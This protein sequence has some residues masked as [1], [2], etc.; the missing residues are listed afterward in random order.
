MAKIKTSIFY[1]PDHIKPDD[2]LKRTTHLAIG[3]HPDDIEM[4]AYNGIMECFNQQDAWFGGIV[5][6]NGSGSSRTGPYKTYT[7]KQMVDARMQEQIHAATIG[8]YSF[9][10]MYGSNSSDIFK[11]KHE[12]VIELLM[13]VFVKI[14]PKI[15]YTHNLLDK[16]IT[17]VQTALI[18]IEALRRVEKDYI[19]EKLYG[20]E[21]WR[22]LDWIND[23]AKVILDV[24]K[25]P[26]LSSQLLHVFNSQ[27]VGGKAYDEGTLGRRRAHAVFENARKVDR[28]HSVTLAIDLKPLI[29]NHH[30]NIEDFIE[31]QINTF[32]KEALMQIETC[33][34]LQKYS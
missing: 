14:K 25:F 9:I 26:D 5:I 4:M 6:T 18:V 29:E 10:Q 1:V 32:K 17:H 7:N 33:K 8:K 2:A 27:I 28:Q 34:K 11:E 15:I 23:S 20:C 30:L 31:L 24:S 12:A 3:A 13:S 19:P 21:V 16:H 22:D